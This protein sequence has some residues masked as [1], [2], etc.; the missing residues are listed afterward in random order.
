MLFRSRRSK[1]SGLSATAR[2]L[3]RHIGRME[4]LLNRMKSISERL[5][6]VCIAPTQVP[7]T[8]NAQPASVPSGTVLVSASVDTE[9][10]VNFLKSKIPCFL[11]PFAV[12]TVAGHSLRLGHVL[13]K[14]AS[15]LPTKRLRSSSKLRSHGLSSRNSVVNE[16][17]AEDLAASARNGRS[18][19]EY[20]DD[21]FV[22]LE[23][24]IAADDE[25]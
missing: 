11:E 25:F 8:G 9:E 19:R 24:F 23:G 22:D 20:D 13:R 17:L 10:V 7:G 5:A 2:L 3:V 16:W 21:A 12:D 4:L 15:S 18:K 6:C 1:A 14:E